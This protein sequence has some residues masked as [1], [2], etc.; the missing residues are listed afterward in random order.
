[1]W[2]RGYKGAVDVGMNKKRG[3]RTTRPVR[4]RKNN[5]GGKHTY[6]EFIDRYI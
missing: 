6:S 3:F 2:E 1:V 4:R 5:T